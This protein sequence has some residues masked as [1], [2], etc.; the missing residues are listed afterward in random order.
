MRGIDVT[1]TGDVNLLGATDEQ[2]IEFASGARRVIYTQDS[3]FVRLHHEGLPHAGIVYNPD[4]RRSI[5]E[6]VRFL[7][8]IHDC[9]EQDEMV[10]KVEFL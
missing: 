9:L 5:G 7:C 2:H 4:G 6:V 8:L 3:D 10:G 1:T